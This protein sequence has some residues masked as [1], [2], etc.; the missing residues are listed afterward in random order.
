VALGGLEVTPYPLAERGSAFD[1]SLTT[2]DVDGELAGSLTYCTDLFDPGTMARL[3]GHLTTLLARAVSEPDRPLETLDL[4]DERERTAVLAHATG[5]PLPLPEPATLHARFTRCAAHNRDAT[6]LVSAAEILTYAELDERSGRLAARLQ[7]G[8]GVGPGSIV[9][10]HL[11]RGVDAI[12]AFWATL[13]SG[14]AY[15]PLPPDLPPGRLEWM[16]GDARPAVVVTDRAHSARLPAGAPPPLFAEDP[17]PAATPVDTAGPDDVAYVLFTS[18]STGR[19]KGTLLAHRGA[20]NLAAV[21]AASLEITP[22]S[23][24]LQY[25]ASAYDVHVSDIVSAHLSGAALHVP[26]PEATVPGQALVDLLAQRRI[27]HA[28]FAPSTLAAMPDAPLPGLT[29]ILCGGESCPPEVVSRW[30]PG[31]RFHNAYGPT[32]TTVC[33]TWTRCEPDRLRPSIGTPM[34]NTRVYVLDDRM[35]PVPVGVPGELYIGGICVGLGY[36]SRPELTRQSFVPDPFDPDPAARL[37]RTGDRG[38][39]LADGTLDILGRLD[40]QV[41]IRGVRV[42]PGEVE[43]RMR[44]LLGLREVAVVARPGPAGPDELV[45]YLVAP[46]RRRPVA[47]LRGLLRAELP[48]PW[49]PAA[50]VHLDALPLNPS[51]KLDKPALP[52][53]A[54]ADRGLAGRLAPRTELERVVAEVWAGVLGQPTVGV[55]DHFFDELGGSSLLVGRVTG[56]LSRRL[57][58]DVPVTHMF[59]HP[60]V[61]ALARRLGQDADPAGQPP[62]TLADPPGTTPEQQAARRRRALARRTR[63]VADV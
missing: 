23:R 33:V 3:A 15:L 13:R 2:A 48:E 10:V 19:P 4:M 30:A 45:A 22:A 5:P 1:L 63:S 35:A 8:Y 25:A 58:R 20:C 14:G 27:T 59:E 42:E 16:L 38:R 52:P 44:E 24:V 28:T 57:G 12:V 32:E 21:L 61:E 31:R 49:L 47:E 37:Y 60:T 53:P 9:G 62:G 43:V 36:L 17:L 7:A 11:P 55:R 41:K 40:D 34:P 39:W 56:E 18:G 6:A 51:G 26:T 54:P 50:F 46:G 29:H